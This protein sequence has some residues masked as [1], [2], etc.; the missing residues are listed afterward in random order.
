MY[1]VLPLITISPTTTFRPPSTAEFIGGRPT[2]PVGSPPAA[3]GATVVFVVVAVASVA[4]PFPSVTIFSAVTSSSYVRAIPVEVAIV[5]TLVATH[6]IRVETA[7][8]TSSSRS[9]ICNP[10]ATATYFSS[11][12]RFYSNCGI[13]FASKYCKPKTGCTI[14][15]PNL[16]QFSKGGKEFLKITL[17]HLIANISYMKPVTISLTTMAS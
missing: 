6:V 13:F 2:R 8:L 1:S 4:S 10:Y 5:A 15:E 7:A 17:S 3:A 9:G 16:F 11:V 12:A 14:S